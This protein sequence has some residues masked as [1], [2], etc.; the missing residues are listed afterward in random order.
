MS[1]SSSPLAKDLT[2]YPM[3]AQALFPARH[4]GIISE[5]GMYRTII[6]CKAT[7]YTLHLSLVSHC[8]PV[9][10]SYP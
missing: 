3:Y 1:V 6:V 4:G 8:F 5:C 9:V 10:H 2:E 7:M